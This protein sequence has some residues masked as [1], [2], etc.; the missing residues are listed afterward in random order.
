M[1]SILA[2]SSQF[3][4]LV[5]ARRRST[6]LLAGLAGQFAEASAQ[7]RSITSIIA[8]GSLGR[9]EANA[10]SDLDCILLY[11]PGEAPAI[12][13]QAT[14]TVMSIVAHTGLRVPKPNGIYRRPVTVDSLCTE[15]GLGDLAE[16]PE[17]FGKRIQLLL[18]ARAITGSQE[19]I[20]ARSRVVDWYRIASERFACEGEWDYLARDLM[21]YAHSYWNWQLFKRER[22]TDD[23]WFLRQVKLR[24][25][26]LLTWFGLWA[27][28]C[29]AAE[30]G[31]GGYSWFLT[32]LD[33]TPLERIERVMG[34]RSPALFLELVHAYEGISAALS[35]PAVRRALLNSEPEFSQYQKGKSPE[36]DQLLLQSEVLRRAISQ[37]IRQTQTSNLNTLALAALCGF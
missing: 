37:F 6:T 35:D 7:L 16:A 10:S 1:M 34:E 17:I 31:S 23:S 28:L 36:F 32:S 18:D 3:P 21:R 25:S 13:E 12:V 26:R 20:N 2:D 19:Y 11:R 29:G 24:S 8:A 33:D 4:F 9:L 27:L 14:N 22:T 5:D 30:R 15:S